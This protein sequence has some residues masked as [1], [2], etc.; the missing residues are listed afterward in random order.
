MVSQVDFDQIRLRVLPINPSDPNE[1][2]NWLSVAANVV[3]DVN[4]G[5]Q[6][7]DSMNG[8][9][10]CWMRPPGNF[11]Q[12]VYPTAWGHVSVCI[13]KEARPL[14]VAELVGAFLSP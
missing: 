6:R 12:L 2:L 5:L 8:S 10:S 11:F 14:E 13:E 9:T 3:D 4:V 7:P 1:S